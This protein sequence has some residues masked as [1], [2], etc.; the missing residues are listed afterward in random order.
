MG[1]NILEQ[2]FSRREVGVP[3]RKDQTDNAH[4]TEILVGTVASKAKEAILK[5][6]WRWMLR[7]WRQYCHVPEHKNTLPIPN[8]PEN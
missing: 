6:V 8:R 4:K 2:T 1:V 7:A 3:R 5:G